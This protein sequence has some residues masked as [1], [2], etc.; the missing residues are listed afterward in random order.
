MRLIVDFIWLAPI[1]E[2]GEI[3]GGG[4]RAG[5]SGRLKRSL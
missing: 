3:E 2:W 1:M 5:H 4:E